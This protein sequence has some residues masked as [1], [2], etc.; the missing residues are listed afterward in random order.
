MLA[1]VAAPEPVRRLG[2]AGL[3][4]YLAAVIATSARAGSRASA[5][6]AGSLPAVFAVMHLSWGFG[7]LSGCVRFGPPFA[8]LAR[9]AGLRRSR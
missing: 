5:A 2:R 1:A 9:T 3:A 8:A 6:D 4:A 7:F